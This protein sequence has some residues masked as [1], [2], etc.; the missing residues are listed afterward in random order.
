MIHGRHMPKLSSPPRSQKSETIKCAIPLML[1]S[2]G[3]TSIRRWSSHTKPLP[4]PSGI[5]SG[6]MR[7]CW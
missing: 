4:V 3:L 1:R 5:S 7:P 6:F 2:A